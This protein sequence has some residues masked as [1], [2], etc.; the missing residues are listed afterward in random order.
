MTIRQGQKEGKKW[1]I[2]RFLNYMLSYVILFEGDELNTYCK[3]I[4]IY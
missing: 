2:V 3:P 4:N 1:H